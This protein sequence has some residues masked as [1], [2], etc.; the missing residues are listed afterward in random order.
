MTDHPSSL[1][2]DDGHAIALHAWQSQAVGDNVKGVVHWLHGMAEHGGRHTQLAEVLNREGWHLVC[3]DHRGH[4]Q[5]VDDGAPLGHYADDHGW[6]KVQADVATVQHW[7]AR[8]FP[9][10]PVVLAGHSMGSFIARDY[11]EQISEQKQ[12]PLAGLIICGS[13]Y[14]PPLYYQLMRLPLLIEGLRL[15]KR[16]SSPVTK[17]VTFS[18]WN[19]SFKPNRTDFDWL[20]RNEAAVDAYIADPLCGQDTSIQLWLDLTQALARMDHPNQLAKLPS[21]LPL[22]LIGG[23]QD[24]MSQQGKGMHALKQALMR[25]S[26]VQLSAQQFEGRH[27]I[28]HDDCREQVEKTIGDWLGQLGRVR[29]RAP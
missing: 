8:Q 14:H 27:E 24:A 18:A 9:G 19:K 17:A 10:L 25:H 29:S 26:Q 6:Q 28:L 4:G 16:Q 2:A 11:A 7:I 20:A 5:S 1:Q 15:K 12:P 23:K 21:G 22:L 3:H 13:D